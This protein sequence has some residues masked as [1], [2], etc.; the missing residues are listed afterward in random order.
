M[1]SAPP[2]SEK[3]KAPVFPAEPQTPTQLHKY[4]TDSLQHG[5]FVGVAKKVVKHCLKLANDS[6][7][8]A[9]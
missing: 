4:H 9:N 2:S 1:A 8:L 7:T 5:F 3:L 6:K